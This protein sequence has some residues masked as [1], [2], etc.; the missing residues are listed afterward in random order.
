MVTSFHKKMIISLVLTASFVLGRAP[1]YALSLQEAREEALQANL[2][3]KISQE[4]TR[5]S[6]FLYQE[7]FTKFLPVLSLTGRGSYYN[8]EQ[9]IYVP[10]GS[11]GL[12]VFGPIPS[13]DV[14]IPLTDNAFYSGGVKLQ[15]PIFQGGRIYYSYKEDESK[16]TES[17]WDEKQTIQ[18]TLLNVEKAY[19]QL[20]KA[21]DLKN[22]AE[23][24]RNTLAAN[25]SDVE[26]LFKHGRVAYI[27]VL[28]VKVEVSH[29]EGQLVKAT[30]DVSVAEG[31]LNLI[32]NRPLDQPV[33]PV[34]FDKP[35]PVTVNRADANAVAK[36]NNKALCSA[37]VK[38]TTAL[39]QRNVAEAD[40]YPNINLTTEYS[41]QTGQQTLPPNAWSVMVNL[42]WPIW[43]WGGTKN[44]V[45]AARAYERQME[46]TVTLLENQIADE[47][48]SSFF[49]IEEADTRMEIDNEAIA[50]SEENLRITQI[51]FDQGRKT[52]TDVLD[53]EDQLS[54]SRSL[55]IQDLYD[56]HNARAQLRYLMGTMETKL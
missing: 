17:R 28:K 42:D 56:A 44:K 1:V 5:Q 14:V 21:E 45:A 13:S 4:K 26:K 51:G 55:Y 52:S 6:E 2:D 34:H 53:A 27:D 33:Q 29:A 47:V 39:Y 7:S 37:R 20:L 31:K 46:F 30:N 40:Y 38:K 9:A 16:S 48:R 22:S 11:Y 19:S 12:F 32:V 8:N 49:L 3:I 43:Q 23:Q 54:K 10:G 18:D 24:H 36:S 41:V 50:R 15:Q 25:L 35:Q